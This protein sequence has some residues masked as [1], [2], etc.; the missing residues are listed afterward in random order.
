MQILLCLL[1]VLAAWKWGDWRNWRKYYP[2]YV[3]VLA[4]EA[5]AFI[6]TYNHTLWRFNPSFL[7]PDHTMSEA[8]FAFIVFP[9]TVLLYLSRYPNDGPGK[10]AT[11]TGL[12]IAGFT[13]TEAVTHYLG[14]IV[15]ENGWC[16]GWS[17][18]FNLIMFPVLR[19]HYLQPGLAWCLWG[20]Y[21]AFIWIHFG[22]G[23]Q[24]LK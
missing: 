8:S 12:W 7:L 3:Y 16:I 23:I 1:Y 2:T 17:A 5:I 13:A 6:V 22:F 18:V 24:D 19:V 11:W 9:A 14:I 21:A 15:Y 4:S 10:Q 20:V